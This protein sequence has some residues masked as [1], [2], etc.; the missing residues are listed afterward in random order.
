MSDSAFQPE[1]T[2]E[3]PKPVRVTYG[4][5]CGTG[6]CVDVKE[7]DGGFMF[8]STLYPGGQF[9]DYAEIAVFLD[10]VKDGKADQILAVAKAKAA[11]SLT[12]A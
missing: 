11:E 12:S 5:K 8:T 7:V 3:K 9:Y 1:T 6:P 4:P 2:P 10:E